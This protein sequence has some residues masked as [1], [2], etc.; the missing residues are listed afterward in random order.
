M[1][2]RALFIGGDRDHN[3]EQV[4]FTAVLTL[5]GRN[6]WRRIGWT[7]D[8]RIIINDNRANGSLRYPLSLLAGAWE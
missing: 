3:G 1:Q 4:N 5:P 8:R 6:N 2:V 7:E